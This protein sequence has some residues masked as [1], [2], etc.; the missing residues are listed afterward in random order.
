MWLYAFVSLLLELYTFKPFTEQ[1]DPKRELRRELEKC[2]E[3][4]VNNWFQMLK[5]TVMPNRGVR[6][7]E[8]KTP[9]KSMPAVIIKVTWILL[10]AE[11]KELRDLCVY[12]LTWSER[13]VEKLILNETFTKYSTEYRYLLGKL[14]QGFNLIWWFLK[15]AKLNSPI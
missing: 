13:V 9:W 2:I 6:N 8:I 11:P 1:M 4:S 10:Q 7:K 14:W 5:A 12:C 3:P 15:V